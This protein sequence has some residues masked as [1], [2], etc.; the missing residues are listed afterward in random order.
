MQK[1]AKNGQRLWAKVHLKRTDAQWTPVLWSNESIFQTVY[2]D[3]GYF[4][5][6]A[7]EE[8]DHP[9]CYQRK[10]QMPASAVIQGCNNA[11]VR[12]NLHVCENTINTDIQISTHSGATYA[13]F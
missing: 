1:N 8:K 2:V 9:D 5:L 11:Q 3:N 4:V 13:A 10:I 7:K 6:L 12:C